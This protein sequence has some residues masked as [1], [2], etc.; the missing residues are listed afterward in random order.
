MLKFMIGYIV[1]ALWSWLCIECGK[2]LGR[3]NEDIL[4]IFRDREI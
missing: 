1:F 2:D 4:D 3:K